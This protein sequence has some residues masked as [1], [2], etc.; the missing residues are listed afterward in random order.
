MPSRVIR[1]RQHSHQLLCINGLYCVVVWVCAQFLWSPQFPSALMVMC[2]DGDHSCM[3]SMCVYVQQLYCQA[4]CG[5][6]Y[7]S[8]PYVY[9]HSWIPPLDVSGGCQFHIDI[10][11][12]IICVHS[13]IIVPLYCGSLIILYG[14]R[15]WM[16]VTF[17][18]MCHK[19]LT[20]LTRPF[21]QLSV[22]QSLQSNTSC[23]FAFYL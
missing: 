3:H 9:K 5:F 18:Y 15:V 4:K 21:Y 7:E 13:V 8:P 19:Q 20:F 23:S 11:D 1:H 10:I 2:C 12:L 22:Q 16:Q 14:I 6:L 17:C